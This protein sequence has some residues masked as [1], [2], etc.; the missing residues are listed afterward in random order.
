MHIKWQRNRHIHTAEAERRQMQGA[1]EIMR[2]E[3]ERK[4]R[5]REAKKERVIERGR[6]RLF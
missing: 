2:V 1:R 3:R 4:K 5:K 6:E